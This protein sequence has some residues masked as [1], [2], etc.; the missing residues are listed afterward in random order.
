VLPPGSGDGRPPGFKPGAPAAYWI[1]QGPRGRWRIRTTTKSQPDVFRGHVQG[2][3]GAIVDVR[4]TSHEL[5]DRMWQV[6]PGW[7]F[8][9]KTAGHADGFT[10]ATRGSGCVRFDLLVDGGPHAKRIFV[11]R[12]AISP[13]TNHFILCPKGKGVRR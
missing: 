2:T 8:S 12:G 9:F 3:D 1:W 11:G 13:R 5:R 6:D 4:P 7:A 10:F